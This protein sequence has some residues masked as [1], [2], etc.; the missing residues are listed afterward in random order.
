MTRLSRQNFAPRQTTVM[1]LGASQSIDSISALAHLPWNMCHPGHVTRILATLSSIRGIYTARDNDSM[2]SG[3]PR[4]SSGY[5]RNH[6]HCG[7]SHLES[8]ERKCC[9]ITVVG[10]LL[11]QKIPT[12]DLT[13]AAKTTENICG[14]QSW[15]SGSFFPISISSVLPNSFHLIMRLV[16]LPPP[17]LHLISFLI[18]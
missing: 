11:L 15:H 9:C 12:N 2:D 8:D 3:V 4:P 7:N 1:Q 10:V 14:A 17:T 18:C 6:Q 13:A 5:C 16:S